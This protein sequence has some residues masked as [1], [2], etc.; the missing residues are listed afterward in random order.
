MALSQNRQDCLLLDLNFYPNFG[1][2]HNFGSRYARMPIMGYKD[3]DD[4][5]L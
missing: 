4:D 1:L 2:S 3:S 5:L